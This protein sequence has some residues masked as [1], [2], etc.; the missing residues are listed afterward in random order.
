MLIKVTRTTEWYVDIG[1]NAELIDVI[2]SGK[3][4]DLESI[5]SGRD[6]PANNVSFKAKF[7]GNKV[8]R[9]SPK[10]ETVIGF[11]SKE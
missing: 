6:E 2:Q 3:D 9:N 11:K 1:D 5:V 4:L 7:I 10:P 8:L